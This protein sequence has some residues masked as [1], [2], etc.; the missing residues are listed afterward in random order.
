MLSLIGCKNH[1]REFSL[2]NWSREGL[3][4]KRKPFTSNLSESSYPEAYLFPIKP[5]LINFRNIKFK[6]LKNISGYSKIFLTFICL[7]LNLYVFIHAC[8]YSYRW[9]FLSFYCVTSKDQTQ[10]TKLGGKCL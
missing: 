5:I 9:E 4:I 3:A 8:V 1:D 2:L 6:Y 7:F 10:I